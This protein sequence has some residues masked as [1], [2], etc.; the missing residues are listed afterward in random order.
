MQMRNKYFAAAAAALLLS[1]VSFDAHAL[2]GSPVSSVSGAPDV[3]LVA[4]G[5]GAGRHRD[6]LGACVRN[7][8]PVVVVPGG[9][10]VVEPPVVV[11]PP[12]VAPVVCGAGFRWHPRF[13]RCVVL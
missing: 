11:A 8:G 1:A 6:V 10:V 5:C 12:V 3:T 2:P 4:E 13:K 7:G 9:P